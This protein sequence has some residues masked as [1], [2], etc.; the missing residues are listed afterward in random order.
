MQSLCGEQNNCLKSI[1]YTTGKNYNCQTID[2][3]WV[4][5]AFSNGC[6]APPWRQVLGDICYLMIQPYDADLFY[7]TACTE[8]YFI[9][10][11]FTQYY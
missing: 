1:Q 10:N 7:V 11:V 6:R 3:Y 4:A 2:F 5:L 9:N 8:G